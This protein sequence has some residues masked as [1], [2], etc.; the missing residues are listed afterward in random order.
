MEQPQKSSGTGTLYV[1][2]TPIGNLGDISQRLREV[3]QRVNVIAA[4]D[5]RRTIKLLAHIGVRTPQ[6]S[7][8]EHNEQRKTDVL[9]GKLQ[10]GQSVA[11]VSDAGMP[12][13]SD[14]GMALV[15]A[16]IAKDIAVVPIPGPTAFT[17][18]LVASGLST[19]RFAFEGFLPRQASARQARLEALQHDERTLIFYEAPHRLR[20]T[21][22][23]MQRVFG[24]R[25]AVLARELTKVHEQF[26][27]ASLS[28]IVR[29]VKKKP[30]RGEYVILIAGKEQTETAP[31]FDEDAIRRELS[32]LLQD[33]ISHR[34]AVRQV[35]S[36]FSVARKRVYDL[37]LEMKKTQG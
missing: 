24:E 10:A 34:D 2:G 7:L 9:I 18:A 21:L 22:E 30:A 6:T 20:R 29:T 37:A 12:G 11:L 5:T 19:E 31:K 13:I 25:D 23:D 3:L 8:H 17:T 27:R 16:C 1:C 15:Q 14:P 26:V 4:E 32:R 28:D 33:G 36:D 35:A